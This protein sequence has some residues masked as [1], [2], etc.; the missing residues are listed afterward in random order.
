VISRVEVAGSSSCLLVGP[1]PDPGPGVPSVS[2]DHVAAH[3]CGSAVDVSSTYNAAFDSLDVYDNTYGMIVN[4]DSVNTVVT[5]SLFHD[6]YATGFAVLGW[7]GHAPLGTV[8]TGNSSYDNGESG[9]YF[10][11]AAVD[12][13]A[14]TSARNGEA[15]YVWLEGAGGTSVNDI[16]QSNGLG[17]FE[18]RTSGA[19]P[20]TVTS[21]QARGNA[22]SGLL[23]AAGSV[24]VSAGVF[25]WN[26]RNGVEVT[27]GRA[28]LLH[29][30]TS[31]NAHS[32]VYFGPA[33]FG[34]ATAVTAIKNLYYGLAVAR[35]SAFVD[36]G[37]HTLSRNGIAN[38]CAGVC[39]A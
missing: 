29:V 22:G 24:V 15:G 32:G 38:R 3:D 7:S 26:G 39:V 25:D 21:A 34:G 14:N 27:A 18:V 4:Y 28:K 17:G 30:T 2:L 5:N 23:G 19:V 36:G 31:R 10:R 11:G 6:N 37:G 16:A 12:T 35:G 8:V 1:I 20:L 13:S 33:S 9:F